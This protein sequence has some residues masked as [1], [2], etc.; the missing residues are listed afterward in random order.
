[1]IKIDSL[2]HF[3]DFIYL[4]KREKIMGHQSYVLG[5]NTDEEKFHILHL[6]YQHN[7]NTTDAV[8][9]PL[10]GVAET[11]IVKPYKSGVLKG[12]TKALVCGHG[13]GRNL[14]RQYFEENHPQIPIIYYTESVKKRLNE[15]TKCIGWNVGLFAIQISNTD[16]DDKPQ[17]HFTC[18][19]IDG[20]GP[21]NRSFTIDS[22]T[23]N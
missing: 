18:L 20:L 10:V 8:G 22:D 21:S 23:L 1:M 15:E 12:Y 9:E 2:I 13:G 16:N 19:D 11:D 4:K 14:T 17:F 3:I 6:I 5:F 7:N